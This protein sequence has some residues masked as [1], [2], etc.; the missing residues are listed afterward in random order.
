MAA[1]QAR[2]KR[3]QLSRRRSGRRRHSSSGSRSGRRPG[4]SRRTTRRSG[5]GAQVIGPALHAHPLLAERQGPTSHTVH[6][7]HLQTRWATCCTAPT[8]WR[9]P[10]AGRP[11]PSCAW[12]QR[13][14]RE[15][16][17]R[18]LKPCSTRHVLGAAWQLLPVESQH[19][20]C[21]LELCVACPAAAA[22]GAP[23][24]S[25]AAQHGGHAAADQARR[26]IAHGGAVG[27]GERDWSLQVSVAACALS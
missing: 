15:S 21:R 14:W 5:S 1:P 3:N 11:T 23:A 27:T 25:A 2:Q 16:C 26:S 18:M 9:S 24:A 4:R 8:C 13:R 17:R 7:P 19:T 22:A 20:A 10:W 12:R 6:M